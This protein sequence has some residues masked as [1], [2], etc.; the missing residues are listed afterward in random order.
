MR[1]LL[2]LRP[3]PNILRETAIPL[4]LSGAIITQT[5]CLFAECPVH[6]VYDAKTNSIKKIDCHGTEVSHA[7]ITALQPD[8]KQADVTRA[9]AG[10]SWSEMSASSRVL[11][12]DRLKWSEEWIQYQE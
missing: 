7:T 12:Q 8:S 2:M 1:E 3:I 6:P 9:T 11:A 4:L 5:P 10:D